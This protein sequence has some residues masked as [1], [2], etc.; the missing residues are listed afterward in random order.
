VTREDALRMIDESRVYMSELSELGYN[1]SYFQDI[2]EEETKLFERADLADLVR[3]NKTASLSGT[4]VRALKVLD[5]GSFGYSDVAEQYQRLKSRYDLSYEI[6][7]SIF[8]LERRISDH[9]DYAATSGSSD[10]LDAAKSAF[11]EERYEDAA[12]YV[13]EGNARLDEGIAGAS[14]LRLLAARSRDFVDENKYYMLAALFVLV[15]FML[16][17]WSLLARRKLLVEIGKLKAEQKAIKSLM[18]GIQ[19]Q[20]FQKNLMSKSSYDIR[21]RKYRERLNEI[22]RRI[23]VLE[24]KLTRSGRRR[25]S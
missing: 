11:G 15:V 18:K 16:L 6:S 13:Q 20:R 8:A 14:N 9:S 7:D 5:Y 25:G 10:S 4:T 21:L 2:L 23:P 3:M 19:V 22:D 24:S 17:L 12:S 1:V